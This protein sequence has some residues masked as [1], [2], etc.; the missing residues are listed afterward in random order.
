[1]HHYGW[2]CGLHIKALFA[3][4]THAI[5]HQSTNDFKATRITGK[6]FI[7]HHPVILR[8][9]HEFFDDFFIGIMD[10]D[11]VTVVEIFLAS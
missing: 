6:L 7:T 10:A 3:F 4:L 1:M 5:D 2:T 11:D 8:A 9:C